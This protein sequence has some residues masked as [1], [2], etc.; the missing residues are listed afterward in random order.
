[1]VNPNVSKFREGGIANLTELEIMFNKICASAT[2]SWNPYS[3]NETE[4]EDE[5]TLGNDEDMEHIDI[6][7][8]DSTTQTQIQVDQMESEDIDK[9]RAIGKKISERRRNLKLAQLN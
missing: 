4:V 7:L 9:T 2:N 6:S 5:S 3:Q 1:M 8:D